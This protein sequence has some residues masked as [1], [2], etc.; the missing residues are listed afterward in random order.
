MAEP[1]DPKAELY[2]L[3]LVGNGYHEYRVEVPLGGRYVIR[4]L[5]DARPEGDDR[6]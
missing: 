3:M 6:G 4:P 2:R 5:A 1:R